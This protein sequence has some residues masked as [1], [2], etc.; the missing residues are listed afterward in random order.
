MK[1][2]TKINN[3][4]LKTIEFSKQLVNKVILILVA[5]LALTFGVLFISP[6]NFE[7]AISLFTTTLP[8]YIAV[9]GA[10]FGKAGVENSLK[11]KN[12]SALTEITSENE[13]AG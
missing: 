9:V 1:K 2:K 4:D 5:H 11:I 10:Y 3:S 6:D 8:F 12:S 7:T 13:S